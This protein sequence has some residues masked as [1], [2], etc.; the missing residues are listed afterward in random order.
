MQGEKDT[1]YLFVLD[2]DIPAPTGSGIELVDK[3]LEANANHPDL[4]TYRQMAKEDKPDKV[5]TRPGR[6]VP[7]FIRVVCAM[8]SIAT[9]VLS[10]WECKLSFRRSHVHLVGWT[11]SNGCS[12]L[13]DAS[14]GRGYHLRHY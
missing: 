9:P 5:Y 6:L 2:E 12:P 14:S 1:T 4:D 3:L 8:V 10:D 11:R 7:I 13:E